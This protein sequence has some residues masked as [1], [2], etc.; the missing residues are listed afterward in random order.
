MG[1]HPPFPQQRQCTVPGLFPEWLLFC[2]EI[3]V[4]R[5]RLWEAAVFLILYFVAIRYYTDEI[6][7][8]RDILSFSKFIQKHSHIQNLLSTFVSVLTRP[9]K[10]KD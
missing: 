7:R 2:P 1:L 9:R 3:V 5:G 10:Y 8:K 6:K 4:E